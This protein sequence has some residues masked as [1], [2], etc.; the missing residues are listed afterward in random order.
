MMKRPPQ[1]SAQYWMMRAAEVRLAAE[2]AQSP[3][4]RQMFLSLAGTYRR[5]AVWAD[6]VG[7]GTKDEPDKPVL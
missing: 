3:A 4:V 1:K 5:V 7:S 2:S 6:K